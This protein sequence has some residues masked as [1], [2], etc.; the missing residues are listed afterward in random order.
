MDKARNAVVVSLEDLKLCRFP[1][2]P[3][4]NKTSDSLSQLLCL[5]KPWKTHSAP[6]L[7]VS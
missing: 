5:S 3:N 4:V 7:S 1:G 6:L 2:S